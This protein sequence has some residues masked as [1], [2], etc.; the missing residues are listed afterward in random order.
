MQRIPGGA[1]IY[2]GFLSTD[3][4][5][6][7][8]APRRPTKVAEAAATGNFGGEGYKLYFAPTRKKGIR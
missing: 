4:W 6:F 7:D 1:S 5:G 3:E 8:R 2:V